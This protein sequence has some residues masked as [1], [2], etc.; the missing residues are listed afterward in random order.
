MCFLRH[1]V[2]FFHLFQLRIVLLDVLLHQ[3]D[4]IPGI[5]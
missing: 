5:S 3:R 2:C 4:Y 1:L